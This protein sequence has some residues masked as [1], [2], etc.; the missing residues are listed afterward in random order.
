ML[1]IKNI[2]KQYRTGDLVQNAL[3]DVSL[4]FRDNEFVSILGPSGSGKTTLLNIIGGLDRYDS[5]DLIIND[6]STK[7]YK[8]RDWDSYRNHTIGF[9]FQSYNLIPHQTVLANVELALTI[10]GISKKER[11]RRALEALDEVGLKEQAH[12]RPNQMS[13]GQMQ[14]VAIARALV[15]NPD[16]LL[17]DEPTGALDSETSVQVM[18]LLKKVAKDRLVIMVTHNPELAEE[19]STRIV[20]LKDGK[21]ISDT[22]PFVPE[23]GSIA[24]AEHKN[25][26]KAAMSIFTAFALSFNNL[27]TKKGRTIL[28]AFAGSIGIIGIALILSLSTGFQNYID[29]IQEDTLTSY[30][31]TITSETADMTSALLSMV[32]Q[33]GEESEEGTVRERKYMSTMFAEIGKNDLKSLKKYLEDNS[34][35]VDEM[36]SLVRYQYSVVPMIYTIDSDEEITQLNPSTMLAALGGGSSM[37]SMSSMMM[38]SSGT[39]VFNELIEN[40]EELKDDYNILAG[41]W[42]DNYDE[43]LLVLPEENGMPDVLVYSLGLRSSDEL[44]SMLSKIMAGEA[45]EDTGKALEFT[46]EELLNLPFKVVDPTAKYKYNAEYGIY[47]DMSANQEFMQEVYDNAMDLKI[48]GIVCAKNGS[49]TSGLTPGVAY[50]KE[51]T[52]YVIDKASESEIVKKQLADREVNVFNNKRFDDDSEEAGLDFQDMISVDTELIKS[53]FGGAISE[54]QI[55]SMTEEYMTNIMSSISADTTPAKE[56]FLDTFVTLANDMLTSYIEENKDPVTNAAAMKE[57]QIE[58]V[59]TSFMARESSQK[60]LKALETEYIIPKDAYEAAYTGMLQGMLQM[61]VQVATLDMEDVKEMLTPENVENFVNQYLESNNTLTEEQKAAV[62]EFVEKAMDAWADANA[63][64]PDFSIDASKLEE[65]MNALLAQEDVQKIL[66]TVAEQFGVPQEEIVAKFQEMI[67]EIAKDLGKQESEDP[68]SVEKEAYLTSEMVEPLIN[69]FSSQDAIMTVADTM[70]RTMTETV[71]QMKI[72]TNVGGLTGGLMET[73]AGAFNIDQEKFAAAFQFNLS[74]EELSRLM[75]TMMSAGSVEKNADTNLISLGYQDLDEPSSISF[76]FKDFEAKELF[77]DFLEDYNEKMEAEDEEKVIKYTDLT[78]ILMSSVKTIVDSVSYVLIA[79]VSISLVVSS[80]MIGI[81]TYI[82][83]LERTKEIGVLRAIGASKKNIS[84]IFN[85]E[86]FIVGLFAGLIG[87][88]VTLALVPLI[89]YIIHSLTGNYDI[90]AVL[91]VEGAT[92][93]VIL[94]VVLTLIGG[95]IP[96]RQAAKKD[97][98]LALRSE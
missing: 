90:N 65:S 8:D 18:Q 95:L 21:I 49:A 30:P 82:S 53:A 83:V 22:D 11:K 26:G 78:G 45:V 62:Q 70:A 5:G 6:V 40:H 32:T 48:S 69:F 10:G 80:I 91:P 39:S 58:S 42:P 92:V 67:G 54:E 63:Q 33:S 47:E 12:K 68:A 31:L 87:I 15:N 81:I 50:T 13:G 98:V 96:S 55:T 16:I 60:L 89:N 3:N 57:E 43:A 77:V 25:L 36:V 72:M 35:E 41:E 24:E 38:S 29:K 61:Y 84:S 17:A 97:P 4:N 14:R 94:S 66:A 74:E 79:F 1:Q 88:G 37:A 75:Q 51:L 9:V 71:M 85:A 2:S 44:A 46:Y 7:N 93:L 27:L 76:Y 52:E 59:V 34:K 56:M 20:K 19:Y 64:M 73:M 23:A 86:T 28:T